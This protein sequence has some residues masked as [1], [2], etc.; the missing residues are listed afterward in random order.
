MFLSQ[1]ETREEEEEK[2]VHRGI[3]Y[4]Y[5]TLGKKPGVHLLVEIFIN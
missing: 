1:G 5:E 4:Y 2:A 3:C